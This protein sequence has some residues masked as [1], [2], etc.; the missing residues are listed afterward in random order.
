MVLFMY[1]P[2]GICIY[3]AMACF[4]ISGVTDFIDGYLARKFDA[5][6]T[7]GKILDPIADKLLVITALIMFLSIRVGNDGRPWVYSLLVLVILAR[8]IWIMG[9][10]TVAASKGVV[11]SASKIAKYKTA[12]QMVA[13]GFLFLSNYSFPFVPFDCYTIGNFLLAISVVLS[14]ISAIDYSKRILSL[15]NF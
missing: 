12:F 6:T 13:I 1:F 9:L 7:L 15:E 11:V 14:V 5:V 4:I 8:E 2:T 3:F 10:R